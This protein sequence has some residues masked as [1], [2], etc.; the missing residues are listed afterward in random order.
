MSEL[1]SQ[2]RRLPSVDAL[3]RDERVQVVEARGGRELTTAAVREVLEEARGAIRGGDSAPDREGL[4]ARVAERVE[5][6]LR[7]TLR[8]VI[9]ATGVILQTNLGRAPLSARA[10]E[11][12]HQ[13]AAYSNLEFDL[14]AGQ[15]GSRY[16]HAEGLLRRL[17]GAE[18]ALLVNN[19]AAAVLLTL[20]ALARGR[21][22]VVS[23]GQL[24][25]IG[26]G[27]R[28]PEVLA[29]SGA[30]L[31]EVGTTNRTYASDFE[32]AHG[33]ETALFLH[34]HSS[35]FRLVGFVSEPEVAELAQVAQA[36][37]VRLVVDLGSGA[38]LDTA[39]F[40]LAHEPLVQET[41]AAGADLVTFS[42]DKLLGGP[43]AGVIVGQADL[44]AQIRRHPLTRALR[45]DKFTIAGLSAT[46]LAY[47]T[48]RAV[49]ELPVWQMIA[50]APEAI[51]SRA[52]RLAR[53]LR[54]LE[55]GIEATV[56]AGQ[57][58]VGGGSLPG[59]TLPSYVVALRV[60]SVDELAKRL[61]LGEPAVVGRIEEDRFLIDLR[62]VLPGQEAGLW[63]A[64]ERALA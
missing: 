13:V 35:N 8:P 17:T 50:L 27:F 14:E 26:G 36:K 9:N 24:V 16:Y 18:G 28:I 5:R 56:V 44:I 20:T 40:A 62:T 37:G 15:R 29:Q 51:A 58:T 59:E 32:A 61:R 54:E 2:L 45:V 21:E 47:L 34:V 22:V 48:G 3:L 42:G 11:A 7:P 23:R 57:S 25:E 60:P 41:L 52:R 33:P 30:R 46:L 1:R 6:W 4:V 19:N 31:V 12:M 55:A 43:Q 63:R 10:L 53:R 39:A 49:E 38:L 64:L